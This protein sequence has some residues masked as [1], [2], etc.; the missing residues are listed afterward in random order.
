MLR[1]FGVN[2]AIFSIALD[3]ILTLLALFVAAKLVLQVP[4]SLTN[5]RGPAVI[6]PYTYLAVP[7][8]WGVTFLVL[9]VYD[10]KR[11]YRSIDELQIVTVATVA[12]ALLLA[13]SALMFLGRLPEPGQ[14]DP[15]QVLRLFYYWAAVLGLAMALGMIAMIDALSGVKKLGSVMSL[16]QAKELSALAEQ[17]REAQAES[18]ALP[19]RYPAL[20]EKLTVEDQDL[21]SH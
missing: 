15:A 18:E 5:L 1:R 2:Y 12:S 7:M 3:V 14:T 20:L 19:F 6:A 4:P 21:R 16:E 17:L 10:P 8:L 9:S 13:M 11:I